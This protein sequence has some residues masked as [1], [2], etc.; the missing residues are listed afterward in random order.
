MIHARST[1]AAGL[2]AA[3]LLSGNA[4]AQD[5]VVRLPERDRPLAG[6]PAQ[7]FAVGREN[8]AAHETFGIVAGVA[9]DASDNLYVLDRQATRVMVYDRTGRFITGSTEL[10]EGA[11]FSITTDESVKGTDE[12]VSTTYPHLAADVDAVLSDE[13]LTSALSW[14]IDNLSELA[15]WRASRWRWAAR[16]NCRS[17][18]PT[19][20]CRPPTRSSPASLFPPCRRRWPTASRS[21][22]PTCCAPA[23]A[24]SPTRCARTWRG[25]PRPTW[26]SR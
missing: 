7:V 10:K 1:F 16:S 19:T 3:A 21:A 20:A 5:R 22:S 8:G 23:A 24:S 15:R 9:F 13:R 6:T 11:T 2:L 14:P 17:S 25:S 18:W 4:A 12:I 26:A